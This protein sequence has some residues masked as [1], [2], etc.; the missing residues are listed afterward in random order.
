MTFTSF[1]FLPFF[2]AVVCGYYL[3]PQKWRH[4]LLFAASCYFYMAFV[5]KYIFILLFVIVVDF[6][7]A[8]EVEKSTGARR[9]LFFL[10]SILANVG[11]LFTFKYFN[12]F[13]ENVATLAHLVGWNYPIKSLQ[14]LLPIGL[15]FHIFQSLSYVTEVY[16]GKYPAEKNIGMYATY[17]LFFPQLVAGPIERPQQLLEQLKQRVYLHI[18]T[19]LSGLQLMAWGFFKKLVIADRLA[20]AVDYVYGDVSHARGLTLVITT[21][22]FAIQLYADFSG[23]SDIAR[24]AA[25]VLGIDMM[26]NFTQP[27]FANS[28]AAFWRHWHI[29][30]ST[31][32]RDYFYYPLVHSRK[33]LTR[34][35]LYLCTIITFLVTGLWHGAAWTF[36]ALG[37][38]HGTAI[39][40]ETMS[41]PWRIRQ[42]KRL[43]I[44][45]QGAI[46]SVLGTLYTFVVVSLSWVFFRAPNF[47][48]AYQYFVGFGRGW[49][50]TWS[51]FFEFYISTPQTFFGI[52]HREFL[53]SWLLVVALFGMEY[54]QRR[55]A[56]G[57]KLRTYPFFLQSAGYAL[58]VLLTL[59]M[60]VFG[61]DQFIYFQF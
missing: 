41:R 55:Y 5:P 20:V 3:L 18:D 9:R 16:R 10:G 28:V 21:I 43:G 17:V 14:L 50:M 25:R 54:L 36:V 4:L 38:V 8:Q 7:F 40:L 24:G 39:V 15:S 27:Y 29:S 58:L 37:L 47:E 60:G 30:L 48:T 1:L 6:F 33:Q 22:F 53:T 31:W 51:Q 2:A 12:F 44:N 46:V 34:T 56:L 52:T 19:I 61:S 57:D 42:C 32:F 13:N 45:P 59:T 26:K 49:G 11:I 35:W 23:Y